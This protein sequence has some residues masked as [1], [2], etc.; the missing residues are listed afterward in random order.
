[1][2]SQLNYVSYNVSNN[3]LSVIQFY[4]LINILDSQGVIFVG[5]F[6]VK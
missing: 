1:M 2:Y 5:Q 4:S 3:V 6:D